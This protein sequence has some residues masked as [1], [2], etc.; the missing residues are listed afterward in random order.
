MP[1]LP[2]FFSL[3]IYII[4]KIQHHSSKNGPPDILDGPIQVEE[5][6]K[7]LFGLLRLLGTTATTF[8]WLLF[9]VARVLRFLFALLP[10]LGFIFLFTCVGR[11]F[12]R[13]IT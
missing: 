5:K 7:S 9:L 6:S 4:H 8:L 12:L 10:L 3:S 2:I 1:Q 11:F 13:S